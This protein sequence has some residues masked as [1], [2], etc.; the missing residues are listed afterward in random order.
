MI[1][2]YLK[3]SKSSFWSPISLRKWMRCLRA[4]CRTSSSR[5]RISGRQAGV[6]WG[7]IKA[8]YTQV[9]NWSPSSYI[10]NISKP[11][12]KR[13]TA[14]YGTNFSGSTHHRHTSR[15]RAT[16]G[17]S[18][19]LQFSP[20]QPAGTEHGLW[21]PQTNRAISLS[22]K[23]GGHPAGWTTALT[24]EMNTLK[25]WDPPCCLWDTADDGEFWHGDPSASLPS[26]CSRHLVNW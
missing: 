2:S 10:P 25:S 4:T 19:S 14:F 7:K 17:P 16:L 8:Y 5:N 9:W 3:R 12:H 11:N 15:P 26:K 22:S 1:G 23:Q 13:G 20:H 18:V 6:R 24:D 21:G